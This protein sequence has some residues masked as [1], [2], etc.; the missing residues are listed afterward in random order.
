[1]TH[2][3]ILGA[4]QAGI[5]TAHRILTR[6]E[7]AGKAGRVKL[8]LVS[9]NTHMYWNLASPRGLIPGQ[10]TNEELFQ[11]IA[12]GLKRYTD[13]EVK[14]VVGRA[15][16]LD[17]DSKTVT[18]SSASG[19]ERLGYDILVLA[20]G[21]STKADVV[22]K[23]SGSTEAVK[24][25]VHAFQAR[26]GKAKS[27][28]V[29]GA[30]PTG[31]EFA[32]EL[33]FVYGKEKKVTLLA[34]KTV[35]FD[36]APAHVSKIALKLLQD[37][38]ISIK[39]QA[40]V[41]GTNELPDGRQEITLSDGETLIADMYVPAYGLVPN[42]SYVPARYMDARGYVVVDEYLKVKGAENAWAIGDVTDMEPSQLIYADQQS[43][44]VAEA[45]IS[46][47]N[48]KHSAPYEINPTRMRFHFPPYRML[49][50]SIGRNAGVGFQGTME[51]PPALIL[52]HRKHLFAEFLVPAV[53][54][55]LYE[56]EVGQKRVVL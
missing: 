25:A 20:T 13:S 41:T 7:K 27:I 40:R 11:P 5:R 35:V 39:L 48:N 21:S 6:A 24:D 51:L 54:G 28:V 49:G 15:E 26:V 14:F 18:V 45:I 44:Y 34:S 22:F 16:S 52:Q 43:S 3:V 12:P 10:L 19:N 50:C 32:G 8:T 9:P 30:G 4:S 42:T 55:S 47:L 29:A 23:G 38:N 37:L 33:A 1:M 36:E 2:I 53:D 31:V 17:F 46:V 56:S